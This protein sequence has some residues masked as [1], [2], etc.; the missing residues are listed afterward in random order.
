MT[1]HR[2]CCFLGAGVGQPGLA[3]VQPGRAD[4][5]LLS[6]GGDR[7]GG[8]V[9][10]PLEGQADRGIVGQGYQ[11]LGGTQFAASTAGRA[12]AGIPVQSR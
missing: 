3:F 11:A 12:A 8:V 1:G 4:E 10:G 5:L 6:L 7:D 2:E 9:A